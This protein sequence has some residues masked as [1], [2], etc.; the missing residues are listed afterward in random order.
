VQPDFP[1]IS[2]KA[3]EIQAMRAKPAPF[4]K[5]NHGNGRIREDAAAR[6]GVIPGLRCPWWCPKRHLRAAA[7]HREGRLLEVSARAGWREGRIVS[8]MGVARCVS[9]A[10]A[11]SARTI[12]SRRKNPRIGCDFPLAGY[13][14]VV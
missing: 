8:D 9:C 14:L 7:R 4:V 5:S 2:V 6:P 3:L 1:E 10:D 11:G 13:G 12:L